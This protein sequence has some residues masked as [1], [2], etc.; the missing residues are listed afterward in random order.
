LRGLRS[1]ED[2][3]AVEVEEQRLGGLQHEV[4]RLEE[5]ED[6]EAEGIAVALCKSKSR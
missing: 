5:G 3:A 1:D 2:E 6:T 4:L